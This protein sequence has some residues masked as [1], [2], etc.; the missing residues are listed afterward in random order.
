MFH[1]LRYLYN[2]VLLELE[3][4]FNEKDFDTFKFCRQLVTTTQNRLDTYKNIGTDILVSVAFKAASA[5]LKNRDKPVKSL[6][7][8]DKT[9]NSVL[10]SCKNCKS[11]NLT[12]SAVTIKNI[13]QFE[14]RTLSKI[15]LTKKPQYYVFF[16]K[17]NKFFLGVLFNK[18]KKKV[19]KTLNK[20]IQ[21]ALF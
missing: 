10:L 6:L 16:K 17:N 3:A 19:N 21:P 18:T 1:Y 5:F 8:T 13:G 9:F 4:K 14:T 20:T 12:D 7:K 11:I 15:T 2:F